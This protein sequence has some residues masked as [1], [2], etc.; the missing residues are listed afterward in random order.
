MRKQADRTNKILATALNLFLL[1]LQSSAASVAATPATE[2]SPRSLR[3]EMA[4]VS[5]PLEMS[6]AGARFNADS[7]DGIALPSSRAATTR[8]SI[9]SGVDLRMMRSGQ[10]RTLEFAVAPGFDARVIT[11]QFVDATYLSVGHELSTDGTVTLG[12]EDIDQTLPVVIRMDLA[13][14]SRVAHDEA[15]SDH[16]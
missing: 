13:P 11:F 12:L 1:L 4:N 8:R 10:E 5:T 16:P 15:G 2:E 3:D 6:L 9:T 7:E 14:G